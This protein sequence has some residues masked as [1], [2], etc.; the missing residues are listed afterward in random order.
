LKKKRILREVLKSKKACAVSSWRKKGVTVKLEK[1]LNTRREK[2]A[3][4]DKG[5]RKEREINSDLEI[6]EGEKSCPLWR[7]ETQG[8]DF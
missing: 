5:R 2:C 6:G 1:G 8:E 3:T 4:G 7:S